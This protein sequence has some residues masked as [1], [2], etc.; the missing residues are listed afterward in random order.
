MRILTLGLAALLAAALLASPTTAGPTGTA[1]KAERLLMKTNM[2]DVELELW[3]EVAPETVRVFVGL[4]NGSGTFSDVRD[5]KRQ[6]TISEPFYDG[7]TFHRIIPGFMIQ[8]GCPQGRGSGDAGFLYADEINATALG[9]DKLKAFTDGRPHKY[10]GLRSQVDFQQKILLPLL[11]KMGISFRDQAAIK[12]REKELMQKINS[13][14]VKEAYELQGYKYSDT[15][16]SR[17]PVKGALAL[18]NRGP[19]TNGSQFFIN[20]ED[21]PFL[22]GKHTVFGRVSKGM[23]I[24]EK[25]GAVKT[26]AQNKP[27]SPVKILSIRSIP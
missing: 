25:I 6:V 1:P 16:P 3:P 24:V 9:L 19:N 8:G 20:L 12:A 26:G 5:P 14:S 10:L 13:M 15:L 23:D 4:A 17:P 22:A 18:A 7:L 11:K 2:G 21:T 27:L